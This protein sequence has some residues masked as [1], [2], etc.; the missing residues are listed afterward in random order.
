[1]IDQEDDEYYDEMSKDDDDEDGRQYEEVKAVTYKD[2]IDN[3]ERTLFNLSKSLKRLIIDSAA[4]KSVSG[5]KWF[6]DFLLL[7]PNEMKENLQWRRE[8][9]YFRFG[10]GVRYPSKEEVVL[11]ITLGRLKTV[12]Y[13]SIVD[14]NIPLLLGAPDLKRL[15]ITVNFEK[16]KAYISRTKEYFDI[17]R[18][19]N[20]HLTLPITTPQVRRETHAIM[21]VSE[22]DVKEKKRKI[23]KVHQILG[24]PREEVLK[25]FYK[26]SS[27]DDQET[28]SIVEEVSR[29][30]SVCVHFKRTPSRPKVGLPV[31]SNF[32]QCVAIDL[33]DRKGNKSFILYAVDTF[34]RLTRAKIIKN[35]EP[36]TIVRALIDI[37]IL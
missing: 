33:K 37:W 23:K 4:T 15:G 22:C 7:L 14:A 21:E 20:N 31:S 30:C 29:E 6:N 28:M 11:P 19:E 25:K 24:H 12:L 17:V 9:Q 36:S 10:N 13:V 32:N 35:K 1:M 16:D 27:Q 3:Y 8:N 5:A 34:S 18:D 2:K 26:E